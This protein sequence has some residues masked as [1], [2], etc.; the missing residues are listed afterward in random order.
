LGDRIQVVGDDFYVT[1]TQR[2]AQGIAA[3]CTN[4]I[5]IKVNQIG[6]L[7]EA[8]E[9]IRAAEEAARRARYRVFGC[10]PGTYDAG[11]RLSPSRTS[12]SCPP[13]GSFTS[14][15]MP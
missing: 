7:T 8:L 15:R 11:I 12:R 1:N 10:K 2:L 13:N 14:L 6:T 9:A 5:L 3:G 4:S